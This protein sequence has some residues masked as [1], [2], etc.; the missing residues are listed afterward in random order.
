M[1]RKDASADRRVMVVP[2]K[3][4]FGA[5]ERY[6]FGGLKYPEEFERDYVSVILKNARFE[7]IGGVEHNPELQQIVAWGVLVNPGE[8]RVLAYKRAD[9]YF[10]SRLAGK[11]S[12][13][14]G[15]HVRQCDLAGGDTFNR[16]LARDING[17]RV[18]LHTGSSNNPV[19]EP[20]E[21]VGYLHLPFD[22]PEDVN[23]YHFGLVFR[24]HTDATGATPVG[25]DFSQVRAMT[26]RDLFELI[27]ERKEKFDQWS[28][29]AWMLM[30]YF[31]FHK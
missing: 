9:N 31:L 27:S 1:A 29:N 22:V 24:I 21:H 6:R 14:F 19:L 12:F 8:R 18:R 16:T 30:P 15:G 28:A 23:R 10:D 17:G 3:V 7:E 11:W 26:P 4:L 20:A 5:R 2:N 25:R 13:G